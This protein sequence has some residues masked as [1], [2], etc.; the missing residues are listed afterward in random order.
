LIFIGGNMIWLGLE[1][2]NGDVA[3]IAGDTVL[4]QVVSLFIVT[5]I[6]IPL[7]VGC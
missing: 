7:M 5:Q 1:L 2:R 3:M 4:F 6:F